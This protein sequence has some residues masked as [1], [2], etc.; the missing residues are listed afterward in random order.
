MFVDVESGTKS[1]VWSKT[2]DA[3]PTFL[4]DWTSRTIQ[5]TPQ[6][7]RLL[8]AALAGSRYSCYSEAQSSLKHATVT[9][10]LHTIS[11]RFCFIQY[12]LCRL[13]PLYLCSNSIDSLS[14]SL[15]LKQVLLCIYICCL[16]SI[17]T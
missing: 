5:Q 16:L 12:N 4:D 2:S 10:I 9:R 8:L 11:T 7:P 13:I 14:L 17:R 6:S 3:T 1:L 15:T